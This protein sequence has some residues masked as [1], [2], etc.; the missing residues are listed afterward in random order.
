MMPTRRPPARR[1]RVVLGPTALVHRR[2]G[3]G[4]AAPPRVEIYSAAETYPQE[5]VIAHG[6]KIEQMTKVFHEL[7]RDGSGALSFAEVTELARR[8]YDG[9]VPTEAKVKSI[10]A[11]PTDKNEKGEVTLDA[12]STAPRQQSMQRAFEATATRCCAKR[13]CRG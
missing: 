2:R 8:F 11:S 5:Y 10:F 1:R 4:R 9:R 13:G 7:D 3:L 12:T 6:S